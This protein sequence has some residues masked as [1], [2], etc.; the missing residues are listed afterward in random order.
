MYERTYSQF[1]KTNNETQP[2]DA[3]EESRLVVS[4][5]TILGVKEKLSFSI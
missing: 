4:I 5:L 2:E 1:F 3:L